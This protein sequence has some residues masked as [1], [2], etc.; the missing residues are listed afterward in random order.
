MIGALYL[1]NNLASYLFTEGQAAVLRVGASQ[2]A[3][4]LENADLYRD[5]RHAQERARRSADELRMFFD[6]MPALA[7]T[8]V[9]SGAFEYGSKRWHDYTGIPLEAAQGD[10]W[11]NAFH[12]ER[13]R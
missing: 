6:M 13:S 8:S 11:G 5:A 1:E 9:P 4:S 2:A 7:W 10:G 12:P 3:I